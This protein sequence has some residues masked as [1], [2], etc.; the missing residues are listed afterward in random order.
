MTT[1]FSYFAVHYLVYQNKIS[2][3]ITLNVRFFFTAATLINHKNNIKLTFLSSHENVLFL[4][5]F[6]MYCKYTAY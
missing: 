3:K 5:L 1:V 2:K 4:N 6:T